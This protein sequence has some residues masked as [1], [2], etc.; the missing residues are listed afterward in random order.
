MTVQS[1]GVHAPGNSIGTQVINGAYS[2]SAG[3]TSRSKSMLPSKA[4]S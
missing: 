3:S 2:L 1:G 4:T